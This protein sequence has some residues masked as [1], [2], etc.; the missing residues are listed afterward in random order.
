[1]GIRGWGLVGGILFGAALHA[2]APAPTLDEVLERMRAYLA[3]YAK[4]LPAV[5]AA[6]KYQQ[7]SGSGVR[8]QRRLLESD[9]G[10][11]Q[12]PGDLE[13]LGFREVLAIDGKPIADSAHRLAEI[14][15]DTVRLSAVARSGEP[16][17]GETRRSRGEGGKPDTTDRKSTS[18][19]ATARLSQARQIAEES[20]RYNLGPIYR[21]IND[22]SFVLEFLDVRNSHRMRFSKNGEETVGSVRAWVVKFQETGR[23]TIIQTT[24]RR[25]Q[26]AQGR[27]WVDPSTGR[28]LRAEASVQPGFGAGNFIG[29]IDVIF[30]HDEKLGFAVPSKM[31]EKYT[32]RNLV[33]V[34]F[35][36]ATYSNY[37]RFTVDVEE[38]VVESPTKTGSSP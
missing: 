33:V 18:A 20:A 34:S 23:P 14:F 15:A 19:K 35:G 12:V 1:L 13:W 6:E 36:E 5:I 17:S 2:Q 29:I 38:D 10:I 9:Y 16:S 30:S 11:I 24:D 3:S 8:A 37:R 28:V 25:D 27:A 4:H 26:P 32:N 21:T 31:T 7:R 22:P